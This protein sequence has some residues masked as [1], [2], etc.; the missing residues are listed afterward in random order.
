LVYSEKKVHWHCGE[1]KTKALVLPAYRRLILLMMI[2]MK[3]TKRFLFLLPMNK[4]VKRD[5]YNC[6]DEVLKSNPLLFQICGKKE[7]S[8]CI[9]GYF[10]FTGIYSV[11]P[12]APADSGALKGIDFFRKI[13][14]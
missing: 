5:R 4:L 6:Q 7:D 14:S 1:K 9:Y 11:S 12:F 3:S 10:V 8:A 13:L 2:K